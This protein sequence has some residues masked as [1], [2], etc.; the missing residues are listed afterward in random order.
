[1]LHHNIN[2]GPGIILPSSRII[3]SK[4]FLERKQPTPGSTG[5]RKKKSTAKAPAPAKDK[6]GSKK[7]KEPITFTEPPSQ[8]RDE[9]ESASTSDRTDSQKT[10]EN[11]SDREGRNEEE[12][13]GTSPN[14]TGATASLEN[15][16]SG[17][18]GREEEEATPDNDQKMAE[19]IVRRILEEVEQRVQAV[20]AL[21]R[22]WHER[23]KEIEETIIS[24]TN[25]ETPNEAMDRYAIVKPRARLQ[26][27]TVR[28][29]KLTERYVAGTPK[30][31]LQLRV[32]EMLEVRKGEFLDEIKQIDAEKIKKAVRQTLLFA[33][34]TRDDLI[35][36]EDRITA[37]E[38]E[39]RDDVVLHNEHYQ[40]TED[41]EDKTSRIVDDMDWFEREIEQRFKEVDE[42]LGQSRNEVGSTLDRVNEL[43]N[44][45]INA[46]IAVEEANA[47]AAKEVQDAL[48][49]EAR[50]EK[51]TPRLTE[52][53]IVERERNLAAQNPGLASPWQLK[54]PK[55]QSG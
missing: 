51:E 52:E 8:T 14:H 48:D 11:P 38:D 44:A 42:D 15:I 31:K 40:Q 24:L 19:I 35:K 22:E 27:L 34:K 25:A 53:E 6:S 50:K 43:I 5:I 28:I 46:D 23:L 30:A 37:I 32:L 54:R 47:R 41:L 3:R 55:M 12:D 13:S 4:Q 20:A 49:E 10:D 33:E 16:D 18:D 17:A 45:K 39:Y 2:T 21:Y 9:E 29:Q 1:M 7:G 36:A 26:K